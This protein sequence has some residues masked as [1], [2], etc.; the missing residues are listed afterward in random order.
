MASRKAMNW[1]ALLAGVVVFALVAAFGTWMQKPPIALLETSPIPLRSASAI[2][3]A[4]KALEEPSESSRVRIAALEA[5]EGGEGN[6]LT[7]ADLAAGWSAALDGVRGISA[8]KRA[9]CLKL[10]SAFRDAD[11]VDAL[12]ALPGTGEQ[13]VSLAITALGREDDPLVQAVLL[14]FLSLM[15]HDP[16]VLPVLEDAARFLVADETRPV[17]AHL[18]VTGLLAALGKQGRDPHELFQ[19][20]AANGRDP[21]LLRDVCLGLSLHGFALEQVRDLVAA[22]LAHSDAHARFGAS[23]ALRLFALGGALTREEFVQQFGAIALAEPDERNRLLFLETLGAVGKELAL[24][25]LQ[26]ILDDP[27]AKDR[28]L[29]LAASTIA[30]HLPAGQAM[31]SL[32]GLLETG[33][34]AQRRAAVTALG[35][36]PSTEAI[37]KLEELFRAPNA[38]AEERRLALRSLRGKSGPE[39]D[40]FL[41]AA[42][43]PDAELRLLATEHLLVTDPSILS[44]ADRA[45]TAEALSQAIRADEDVRVRSN[46]LIALAGRDSVSAP[47]LLAE[48][49][50]ADSSPEVRGLAAGC[51]FAIGWA[52]GDATLRASAETAIASES[53]PVREAIRAQ[54]AFTAEQTPAEL[55]AA[56]EQRAKFWSFVEQCD[57][58][59]PGA[60]NVAGIQRSSVERMLALMFRSS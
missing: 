22:G 45:A 26:S 19:L 53:L 40:V 58:D 23:E 10:R 52:N 33:S 38:S 28:D 34:E 24:P 25:L 39:V 21:A 11:L 1:T 13:K 9:R 27:V 56:L 51:L 49:M 43:A 55:R 59:A 16:R 5:G 50:T 42:Q 8:A 7:D 54:L 4:T 29:N 17:A 12:L 15:V 41:D 30:V 18:A 36:L 47:G 3:A 44:E 35:A 57:P 2:D 20:V 31:Q 14:H 46:A 6:G 48:R 32:V 60:K 37:A